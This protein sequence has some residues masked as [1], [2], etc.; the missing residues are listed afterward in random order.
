MSSLSRGGGDNIIMVKEFGF[1]G[2]VAGFV[3][4]SLKSFFFFGG[5][6]RSPPKDE[7]SCLACINIEHET[8]DN[9]NAA[10]TS[11]IEELKIQYL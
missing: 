1:G 5:G 11:N 2:V 10:K 4:K 3:W 8:E 7:M 6:Q 9:T